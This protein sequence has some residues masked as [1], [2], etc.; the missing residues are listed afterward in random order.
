M[1]VPGSPRPS[2][3]MALRAPIRT[4]TGTFPGSAAA[5]VMQTTSE[6]VVAS[7]WTVPEDANG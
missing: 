2:L 4:S 3:Q 6:S 5:S 1:K 7:S